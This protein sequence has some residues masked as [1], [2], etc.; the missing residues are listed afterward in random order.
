MGTSSSV[1]Q[2]ERKLSTA[3]V[4]IKGATREGVREAAWAGK[5]IFEAELVGAVGGK[6]LSGVGKSGARVGARFTEPS[7]DASPTS[8]LS[9]TGPVH[10]ASSGTRP[11]WIAPRN[12]AFGRGGRNGAFA[13][14]FPD[15]EVRAFPVFHPGT[16]G[17]NFAPRAMDR[18]R[19]IAPQV[20]A[21]A[22]RRALASV[23]AA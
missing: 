2:L 16:P 19:E 10:L 22:E 14:Y 6:R 1:A 21:R 5:R 4:K 8:I 13:L 9:F 20:M 23:F 15:G 11:H 3:G 18:V 17:K 12:S 7:F